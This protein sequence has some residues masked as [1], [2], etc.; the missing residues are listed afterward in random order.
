MLE[1]ALFI[2]AYIARSDCKKDNSQRILIHLIKVVSFS[3][4]ENRIIEKD[5]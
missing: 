2:N 3:D 5:L 4:N 1:E